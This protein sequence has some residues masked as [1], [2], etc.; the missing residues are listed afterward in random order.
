MSTISGISWSLAILAIFGISTTLA[1]GFPID[2]QNI[3]F[4]FESMRLSS[5]GNL[6][7]S[8]NFTSTPN[9]VSWWA[10]RVYFPPYSVALL[11]MLSPA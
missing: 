3:A 11:T 6:S 4:V 10:K 9:R 2:S 7:W 1:A 8:P 5:W